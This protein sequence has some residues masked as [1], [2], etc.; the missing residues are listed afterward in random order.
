M[1]KGF[2]C[3]CGMCSLRH[4]LDGHCPKKGSSFPCLNKNK[5]LISGQ[6]ILEQKLIDESDDLK[7]EFANLVL[8]TKRW[9]KSE[10]SLSPEDLKIALNNT[11][12]CSNNASNFDS[13]FLI[14]SKSNIWSWFSFRYLK[15][16][17]RL[18]SKD[19]SEL[20]HE[21]TEY[22]QKFEDYCRRSV[23]ECP[24]LIASYEPEY[25]KPLFVKVAD[26]DGGFSLNYLR[27]KFETKLATIIHVEQRDLVLLT[28]QKG[29]TQLIY[30][31]PRAVVEK[32]FP[33]SQ[34]QIEMLLKVGVLE[35]YVKPGDIADEVGTLL[36]VILHIHVMCVK[37]SKN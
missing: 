22:N 8:S 9:L 20:F 12:L 29:C 3:P 16:I 6:Q 37:L 26:E 23:F 28:Y 30:S 35:C 31:L 17:I 7:L 33:L 34:M 27:K 10:S 24:N 2:K 1:E 14:L 25:H 19:D 18:C 13:I 32:A 5:L 4:F 11:I 36:P 21:F 15:I